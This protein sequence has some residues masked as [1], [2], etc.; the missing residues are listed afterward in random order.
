LLIIDQIICVFNHFFYLKVVLILI[1]MISR[2]K[3]ATLT[4]SRKVLVLKSNLV[5]NIVELLKKEG[6]INSYEECGETYVS[7]KGIV[8]KYILIDLKYK[9]VK[10]KPYITN[11]KRISKP[12]YRVYSNYKNVP[13]VLGGVGIAVFAV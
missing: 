1:D 13:K 5:L 8:N 6:F 9:G 10:Q 12:G 2:I 11:L 7:E 4:K 3:N